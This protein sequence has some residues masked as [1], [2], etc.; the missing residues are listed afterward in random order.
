MTSLEHKLESQKQ[1]K[2]GAADT[3]TPLPDGYPMTELGPLPAHWRVVRL[4]E[5]AALRKGTISPSDAPNARYVGLEHLDSG[6]IR[7]RRYGAAHET[8]SAKA[9]FK[10]GDVLYGKLRPYLDKSAIA[11]WEGVCS[12]DILVLIPKKSD[13]YFMASWMHST[14]VLQHAITTTTGVNHPRTSWKALS[15][16]PIPLP[17]LPEQRAI[18]HVLRTVQEAKEATERV[19]A[20]ARELKKSL[21]RHLFTY[22]PVPVDQADQVPLQE[23]EIGPIPAHWQVVRLEEV[24]QLKLGRTPARKEK[25]YWQQGEFPWVSISDLNNGI[26]KDTKEK[27]SQEAFD[28]VFGNT[29]VPEDT[30]LLSFK[31]TIGKVGILGI[32]AVHNEAIAS[33]FPEEARAVKDFLFF[34]LQSIDYDALLDA[35]VKGKTL[36]KRKLQILP[37]PLPPIPEQQ[38]I[39]CILRAVDEKIQAE[40]RRKEALERLFKALLHHLMTAKVRLPAEFVKRFVEEEHVTV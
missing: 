9:V 2:P 39:A 25:R 38:E 23:T 18:A 17:P 30:L 20:A 27:I 22:G 37:L 19:I 28:E 16:A 6:E 31:L 32:P 7:I 11:E 14:F 24:A 34:L 1:H 36:N 35:Y 13:C 29:F 5:V 3:G 10:P 26:I 4:G 21:M 15:Q 33:I 8:K 12:T 40:E